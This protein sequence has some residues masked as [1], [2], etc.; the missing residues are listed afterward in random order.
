L[1]TGPCQRSRGPDRGLIGD[2][3]AALND[4]GIKR[5]PRQERDVP[6]NERCNETAGIVIASNPARG[7]G[8]RAAWCAAAPK[9]LD[10]QHAAAAAPARQAMIG[11]G[12]GIGAVV[13]G[14]RINRRHR[15]SDQLPGVYDIGLT[16]GARQQPVVADAVKSLWQNVEQEAP[17][18]LVGAEGHGTVPRLAVAVNR[19]G[20]LTP[21]RRPIGTPFR[22]W[23]R[24]VPVANRRDPRA[25]APCP[26]E[27]RRGA[28]AGSVICDDSSRSVGPSLQSVQ[29]RFRP[30]AR[31]RLNRGSRPG[32]D[33][34]AAGRG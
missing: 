23:F 34:H 17:D 27:R 30:F 10:N 28:R 6:A 8:G 5:T 15:G 31:P 18:E 9:D 21:D 4:G 12:V 29:R 1:W 33:R 32:P 2:V 13:R 25:G 26:H 3:E 19:R 20:I 16:T 14:Q 7:A 11:G 22:G 24:L